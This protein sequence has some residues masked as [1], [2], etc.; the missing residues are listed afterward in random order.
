MANSQSKV[1]AVAAI[2]L[3][4]LLILTVIACTLGITGKKLDSIGLYKLLP[5]I[6]TA[7]ENYEWKS[8]LPPGADFGETQIVNLMPADETEQLS[9]EQISDIVRI[10]SKR[11]STMGVNGVNV[12]FDKDSG[13]LVTT[14]KD[15]LTEENI[16]TITQKGEFEF[17]DEEG[18]AFLSGSHITRANVAPADNTGSTWLLAFELDEEGKKIFAD[19]TT[20]M[21]NKQ[22][23]IKRDGAEIISAGIAEPLLDG[24]ASIPGFAFEEAFINAVLMNNGALPAELTNEGISAG[25]P[26]LGENA[27]NK[28]I[29]ALWI[30]AAVICLLFIIKYRLAGVVAAWCIMLVICLSWFFIALTQNGMTLSSLLAVVFSLIVASFAIGVIFEGMAEDLARGRAAKQ[31]LKDSFANSGHI[32]LDFMVA[33]LVLSL[34]LIIIDT[35]AIG[36]FMQ[37]FAIGLLVDLVVVYLGLRLLLNQVF[38]LFGENNSLYITGKAKEAKA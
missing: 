37:L 14:P 26:L 2:T 15:A 11:F 1:K 10:L 4:V 18:N 28:T 23:V 7:N 3:A 6:P 36:S 20:E 22:M 38:A 19:K 33:S 30:A 17:A 21:V 8:A 9:D 29:A 16:K 35:G 32:G 5:W 24:G 34:I 31:A 13:I 25:E 12:S 27:L